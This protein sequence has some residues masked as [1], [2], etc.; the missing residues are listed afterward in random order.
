MEVHS[1]FTNTNPNRRRGDDTAA[2]VSAGSVAG[3]A[4]GA[5]SS[6]SSGSNGMMSTF[7]AHFNRIAEQDEVQMS[8]SGAEFHGIQDIF[9]LLDVDD[10]SQSF[11]QTTVST[12]NRNR[13]LPKGSSSNVNA[14]ANAN[15]NTNTN[16]KH[17][18]DDDD[19]DDEDV[20]VVIPQGQAN[21]WIQLS[22]SMETEWV[23]RA[24]DIKKRMRIRSRLEVST[25][26]LRDM[27]SSMGELRYR[28]IQA[29][30]NNFGVTRSNDQKRFHA[31]FLQA[32]LPKIFG[33]EWDYNSLR[34][35]QRLGLKRIRPEVLCM[36]PRRWGKTWSVAMF[37]AAMLLCVPGIKISI[38]STGK[39]ASC[40]LMDTISTFIQ[41]IPGGRSRIVKQNQEE[42][43]IAQTALVGG[44]GAQSG[45]ARNRRTSPTTS[46]LHAYPACTTS[47]SP[48]LCFHS[49]SLLLSLWFCI[50]LSLLLLLLLL[51]VMVVMVVAVT[52]SSII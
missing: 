30:L 29:M 31:A 37:V 39:R 18:D 48:I 52:F 38:F 20:T 8:T 28:R 7:M 47:K 36:T 1:S 16:V 23:H 11:S 9:A 34:I 50:S 13:S 25:D 4:G 21:R 49:F 44:N 45:A 2:V 17:D 32:C 5:G 12:S 27:R 24:E 10:L 41:N 3:S 26:A 33:R 35:M 14:N 43:F 6:S 42:L 22:K 15:T 19:D 51:L 46:K 40:S